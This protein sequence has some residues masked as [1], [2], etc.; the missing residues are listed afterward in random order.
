MTSEIS[1]S[2]NIRPVV[3]GSQFVL[4]KRGAAP[5][6]STQNILSSYKCQ[7]FVSSTSSS[8]SQQNNTTKIKKEIPKQNVYIKTTTNNKQQP[9][10]PFQQPPQQPL[11]S[12]KNNKN[13]SPSKTPNIPTKPSSSTKHSEKHQNVVLELF[14]P[15]EYFNAQSKLSSQLAGRE[16]TRLQFKSNNQHLNDLLLE[17]HNNVKMEIIERGGEGSRG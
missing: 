7:E 4:I 2:C 13:I 16:R 6:N 9:Q 11:P 3:S 14:N 5:H 10:Q 17:D 1:S 15:K 12:L 8:S